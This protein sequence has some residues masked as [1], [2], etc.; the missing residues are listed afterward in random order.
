[1]VLR[2]GPSPARGQKG[3]TRPLRK[4]AHYKVFGREAH[5]PAACL[6]LAGAGTRHE[7]GGGGPGFPTLRSSC[8]WRRARPLRARVWKGERG[9][10]LHKGL[11]SPLLAFWKG[12][13]ERGAENGRGF[14]FWNRW[15]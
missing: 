2:T 9:R 11:R 10:R 5:A 15:R 14:D 12:L 6:E 4:G 13:R 7:G 3:A 1:M 8:A